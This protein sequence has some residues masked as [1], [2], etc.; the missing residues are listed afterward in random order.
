M[1]VW[2]V[3]IIEALGVPV[4][5]LILQL[6][7]MKFPGVAPLINQILALLNSGNVTAAQVQSHINSKFQG[8]NAMGIG[9]SDVVK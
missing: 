6:L 8:I 9:P 2:L 1:P 5:K 7:E 4:L 3:S